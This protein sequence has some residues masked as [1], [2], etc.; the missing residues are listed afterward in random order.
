VT[1][2][3]PTPAESFATILQ[4]LTRAV[5][6]MMGGERLPLSLISLIVERIRR[7][8][9]R[10]ATLAARVGAGLYT[11]RQPSTPPPRRPGQAPPP[12]N[13]LPQTFGWLLKLVP[14]AV[15][16]RSQLENL[17]RDPEMAALLAAAPTA[18]RRPLRSLCRMLGLPPPPILSPPP[19]PKPPRA[20]APKREKPPPLARSRLGFHKGL[21]KLPPFTARP[22]GLRPAKKPA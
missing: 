10:F 2:S 22:G 5:V 18:M 16:Y 6:A 11:P 1:N 19:R 15:G 12:Q 3:P 8:K 20:P 9:Q 14:D 13:K 4:W 21:P 17:L 7:I